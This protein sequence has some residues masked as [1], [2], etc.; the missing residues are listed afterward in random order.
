MPFFFKGW[1]EWDSAPAGIKTGDIC[2]SVDG[3]FET[4]GDGMVCF[5]NESDGT[6]MRRVGKKAAGCL[7]DGV[8]HKETP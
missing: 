4:W 7:L 8:E 1:G 5:P 6:H 2:L 3:I